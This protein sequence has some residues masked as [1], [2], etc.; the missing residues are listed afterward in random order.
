MK[1]IWIVAGALVALSLIVIVIGALLPEKHTTARSV[2][3]R[4][5][6]AEVWSV[7]AGPPDWRPGVKAYG[8]LE[9]GYWEEDS[10]EERIEYQV[11]EQNSPVRR[12][13]RIATNGLPYGGSWTIDLAP[14]DGGTLLRIREDGEVYNVLFRF[15][16]R[17]VVGHTATIDTYLRDL[18]V[19]LGEPVRVDP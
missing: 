18:G 9:N 13:T 11:V 5:S 15:I 14:A 1:W 3:L 4:H 19:K 10:S 7:V 6:P 16:S 17:F 2:R 12:V 8:T